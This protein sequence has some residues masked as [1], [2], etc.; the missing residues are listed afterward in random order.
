LP[1]IRKIV[2]MALHHSSRTRKKLE[3]PAQGKMTVARNTKTFRRG[4]VFYGWI[5]LAGA[6]LIFFTGSGTFFY[7]YGVFLPTMCD[8]LGWSRTAMAAGLSLG[9]LTFG[10]PGPLIG[11]SIAR[12]G[13]RANMVLG[14][15]VAALGLAGM[16]LSHEVWHVYFFYGGFI[17][18]GT[19]FGMYIAGA[20]VVN[21]WFIRKRSLA[22]GLLVAVG[23][24]GGF[25]FPPLVTWLI[26]TIG[27]RM[28]WIVLAGIN[29]T[30]AV[31]IGGLILIRN[32][33]EDVG[34]V[35]DGI[36]IEPVREEEGIDP[37][38]RAYQSPV[39]WETKQAIRKPTTW[40]ITTLFAA[41]F[42]AIGT[43]TAHQV[44]YLKD[45]GFTPI[46]AAMVLSLISGM[47]IIG[48]LGFGALSLRFEVR[49]LTIVSFVVQL[50]ALAILL[51]T[52]NLVLIYIYAGLF[53][54]SYGALLTALPIFVGGYYG[55][56]HYSQILGLI[57]SLGI[58]TEAVGPV[59]AGAIYDTTTTYAPAFIIVATFSFVGFICAIL[60]RPP[61]MS[62]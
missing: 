57:F 50:I 8:E 55:R 3:Q 43:V 32:R 37:P 21:N 27:W 14:S 31:L 56:T 48:R 1:R 52:K 53:G 34:Q 59:L 41:N 11:A 9:L 44:A 10:L 25:A 5:A 2:M 45:I 62:Q 15:L 23:G 38:S 39:D 60:T 30:F 7:S 29:F 54:I 42:F 17:G 58:V 36:S 12:F 26:Y 35:P 18:L 46:V 28:S 13:P 49:Q 47:S 4:G 24:L 19:G 40:L 20:T 33:P 22:M 16:S 51:V 61:K 6:A